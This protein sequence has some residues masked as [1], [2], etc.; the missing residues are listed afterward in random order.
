LERIV[1]KAAMTYWKYD[2]EIP[3]EELR[4]TGNSIRTAG[5]PAEI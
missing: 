3:Q 2:Q 4:K 5:L 1:T